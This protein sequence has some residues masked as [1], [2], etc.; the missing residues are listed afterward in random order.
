MLLY[1]KFAHGIFRSAALLKWA[2]EKRQPTQ[3]QAGAFAVH[4]E[5]FKGKRPTPPIVPGAPLLPVRLVFETLWFGDAVCKLA[6]RQ[7]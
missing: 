6:V 4:P 2:I 1:G 7:R 3:L 5:R